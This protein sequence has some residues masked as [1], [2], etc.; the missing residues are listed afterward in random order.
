MAR[1]KQINVLLVF[2]NARPESHLQLDWEERQI[3]QAIERSIYRERIRLVS[4]QAATTADLQR[5]LLEESYQIVHLSGH[6]N[7]EGILL[8][9]ERYGRQMVSPAGLAR[10]FRSHQVLHCVVLNSCFSLAWGKA[11]TSVPVTIAMSQ[12]IGDQVSIEFARGFYDAVGAGKSY[13]EAYEAGCTAIALKYPSSMN[14]PQLLLKGRCVTPVVDGQLGESEQAIPSSAERPYV[15]AGRYLIGCAFDLS[16][17]MQT[18][19]RSEGGKELNR[20]QGV[21][22]AWHDLLLGA[23]NSLQESHARSLDSAIDLFVY[24]FGLRSMPVCDLF[25]LLK[26]IREQLSQAAIEDAAADRKR[27]WHEQLRDYADIETVLTHLGLGDLVGPGKRMINQLGEYQA[28]KNLIR[29]RRLTILA[30]AR[31]LGDTT[32]ALEEAL[33]LID[34]PERLRIDLTALKELVFG[35]TPSSELFEELIRRFQAELQQRSTPPTQALLLL[36]SDG[37]F[38]QQDPSPLAQQLQ[39][40]GVM[41]VSC[42]ISPEDLSDPRQLRNTIAPSWGPE[43][44]TMFQL[45]SPLPEQSEVQR[46][47][48]THGW[49]IE[50]QARLFVQVNHTTVLKEFV[51]VVLSLL[52]DSEAARALPPGW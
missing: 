34:V 7:A 18:S 10:L 29:A 17:S 8:A 31:E 30:R 15:R 43:A 13:K 23:R 46:Y 51:R 33:N 5:A 45:S 32:L 16:G 6:G 39:Q 35:A 11:L 52:E 37:R 44:A 47:L 26:A 22:Q 25:S 1:A 4:R 21:E 50:P 38:A 14:I 42:L 27:A 3:R 48:L 40:M 20:L 24:G 28:I 36:I 2:A 19:I 12:Q 41:I 9:D 49:T